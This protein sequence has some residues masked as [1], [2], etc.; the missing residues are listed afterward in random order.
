MVPC[1]CDGTGPLHPGRALRRRCSLWA[2]RDPLLDAPLSLRRRKALR[3]QARGS[4]NVNRVHS[5]LQIL[6]I[7]GA[8]SIN[9]LPVVLCVSRGGGTQKRCEGVTLLMYASRSRW[10]LLSILSVLP[11]IFF[12]FFPLSRREG[13]ITC[14]LVASP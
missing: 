2:R 14:Y 1:R 4:R 9:V 3:V 5:E 11:I 12:F 7:F 13:M 8:S 6:E 10:H